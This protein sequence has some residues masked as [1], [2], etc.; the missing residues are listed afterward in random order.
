MTTPPH[1]GPDHPNGQSGHPVYGRYRAINRMAVLS[2]VFGVLSV[3]TLWHWALG[4]IPAAGALLGYLALLQIREAPEELTGRGLARAGLVLSVTFGLLGY[5]VLAVA[6]AREFPP[7]YERVTHRDL[8]PD[9]TVPGQLIPDKAF[10][11][12]GK[13]VGIEGYMYPGRQPTG[14]KTFFLCP[15][16][17]NCPFCSPNPKPTEM[18]RVTLEGDLSLD[19]TTHRILVG[20]RFHV[21]PQAPRGVPY[22]MQADYL[23][24][25]R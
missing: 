8:Q 6:R 20:G 22:E 21:D 1:Q 5:G 25:P 9:P 16:I 12:Q 15:A 13:K 23:K 14:L 3:L 19:Y 10:D 11:L 18:I 17:P 4:L 2:L 7:G 24:T